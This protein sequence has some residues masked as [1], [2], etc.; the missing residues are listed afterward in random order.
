MARILD[1]GAASAIEISPTIENAPGGT[2]FVFSFADISGIMVSVQGGGGKNMGATDEQYPRQQG[3]P[4]AVEYTGTSIKIQ[5]KPTDVA[6]SGLIVIS[7][8]GVG[9][10]PVDVQYNVNSN[11]MLQPSDKI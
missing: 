3:I 9:A 1:Q 8:P 2:S 11:I 4:Y 10:A 6:F 7:A 5:A